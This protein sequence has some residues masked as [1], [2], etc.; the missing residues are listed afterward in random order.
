MRR[1]SAAAAAPAHK[2]IGRRGR[3]RREARRAREEGSAAAAAPAARETCAAGHE[4]EERCCSTAMV[5]VAGPAAQ[6]ARGLSLSPGKECTHLVRGLL[7]RALLLVGRHLGHER[8]HRARLHDRPPD[9]VQ[10]GKVI[11]AGHERVH[12]ARLQ[13]RPPKQCGR[14]KLGMSGC[15]G[16]ACTTGQRHTALQELW[17]ASQLF[18]GS[19]AQQ[20]CPQAPRPPGALLPTHVLSH[21]TPRSPPEAK[22]RRAERAKRA[23]VT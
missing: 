18:L 6:T 19:L 1:G 5:V 21:E 12:W 11:Q 8:V 2:G 17:L 22:E 9:G 10:G 16:L 14:S 23:G 13:G 7:P 15:T 4:G 20:C 3:V